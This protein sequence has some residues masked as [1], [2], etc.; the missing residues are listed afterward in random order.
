MIQPLEKL[1]PPFGLT[2]EY[3]PVTLSPVRDADLPELVALA[4]SGIH[5][6]DQMPFFVPWTVGTP[7][8]VRLRFLQFHWA[9]RAAMTPASWSLET[10]VRVDGVA[11]GC[12]GVSARDYPVTRTGETGSWLGAEHQGRG[13]GT[14]MRQAICAFMFD[15]LGAAEI[16]SGAFLDNSASLAVSRKVGYRENGVTRMTRRGENLALNQRLVLTPE[17]LNRADHELRVEGVRPLR[18]FLGLTA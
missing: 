17:D 3:G 6:P 11:V 18:A 10:V 14:L 4:Q 16:T 1:W 9:Q 2:I 5:P 15:H 13:I 12:Q 8:E 7:D